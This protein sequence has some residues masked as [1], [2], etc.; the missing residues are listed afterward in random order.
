MKKLLVII[1]TMTAL[2]ANAGEWKYELL[3]NDFGE[4]IKSA[5]I[6]DDENQFDL[7]ISPQK[8]DDGTIENVALIMLPKGY[9]TSGQCSKICD[10]K[11]NI[12]GN[13]DLEPVKLL[14]SNTFKTYYFFG[15][16]EERFL[17][18]LQNNKV[19]KIQLPL[20]QNMKT[21]TFTQKQPLDLKKLQDVK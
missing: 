15:K 14:E 12:D 13:K 8:K 19:I 10:V 7:S 2:S 11:I 21:L 20:Y 5:S 4:D 1:L 16:T 6:L 9:V 3:H 18:Y 17:N